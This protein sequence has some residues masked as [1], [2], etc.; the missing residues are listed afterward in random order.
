MPR[1]SLVPMWQATLGITL[2]IWGRQSHAVS[3]GEARASAG[4]QGAQAVEQVVRLRAEERRIALETVLDTLQLY[5][6]G[7]LVQSR[8]TAEST[9]SQYRVGKVTFASVLEANAGLVGDEDGYLQALAEAQRLAIA[10]SEVSLDPAV[11]SGGGGGSASV[12]GAGAVRSG[13]GGAA[14]SG[15]GGAPEESSSMNAM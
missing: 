1:G 11:V 4:Q 15:G 6:E 9:L 13:G 10:A 2:P 12:P 14:P 7:L 5:R 3:E 8:A